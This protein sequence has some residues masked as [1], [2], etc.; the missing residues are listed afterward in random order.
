MEKGGLTFVLIIKIPRPTALG[1]EV[2][3]S[4]A[5]AASV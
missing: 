4:G 2:L 5:V 1:E 3:E